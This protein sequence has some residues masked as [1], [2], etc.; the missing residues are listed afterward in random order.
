ML[1]HL[2]LF[3]SLILNALDERLFQPLKV[4]KLLSIL[5]GLQIIVFD[6]LHVVVANENHSLLALR[7]TLLD[8]FR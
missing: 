2:L 8:C 1:L 4:I 3:D 5:L 6:F 7:L